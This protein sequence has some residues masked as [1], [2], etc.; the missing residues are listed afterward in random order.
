MLYRGL[1]V[2]SLDYKCLNQR[3]SPG[4]TVSCLIRPPFLG[5][6][7]A[8]ILVQEVDGVPGW[9]PNKERRDLKCLSGSLKT[10]LFKCKIWKLPL[11]VFLYKCNLPGCQL[12]RLLSHWSKTH[13]HFYQHDGPGSQDT[14]NPATIRFGA[15]KSMPT[16]LLAP[17]RHF[18]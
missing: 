7:W 2:Y 6:L 10:E 1:A 11:L 13:R 5:H 18:L 14:I 17:P 3:S 8:S 4:T 12:P 9:W 16:L 15:V